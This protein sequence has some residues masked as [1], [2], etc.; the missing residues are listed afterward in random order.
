VKEITDKLANEL[1][2]QMLIAEKYCDEAEVAHSNIDFGVV[3]QMIFNM[4][5]HLGYH[6]QDM[7]E[8]EGKAACA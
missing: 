5:A 2:S 8:H 1:Y 7:I 4:R 3:G 6:M